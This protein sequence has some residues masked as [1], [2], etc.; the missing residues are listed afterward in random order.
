MFPKGFA[1]L[2]RAKPFS[3][4]TL[5]VMNFIFLIKVFLI[6]VIVLVLLIIL[7]ERLILVGKIYAGNKTTYFKEGLFSFTE[8]PEPEKGFADILKWNTER[9]ST[10]WNEPYTTDTISLT[11]FDADSFKV[12]STFINHATVLIE[13]KEYRLLTDPIFSKRV[14]PFSFIG[15]ARHHDPYLPLK[16]IPSLDFVLISHAHYDHLSIE[17]IK[18]IEEYF[19]PIYVTPLNNGQFIEQAGVPRNRIVEVNLFETFEQAGLR[20]T[21]EKA[22][23]WSA[24]GFSDRKRYLWGSFMIETADKNIYFSGDTGYDTHFKEIKEKYQRVDMAFIPIGAYEPRW[25]MKDYHMNP[26]EA[27]TAGKD[28][29]EPA[30]MGIHFGTFKITDEGRH[31]PERHTKEALKKTPYGNTF[32]VPTIQNGLQIELQ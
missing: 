13:T 28:L 30:V 2:M 22:K 11:P 12:R 20:I 15:P 32:L 5:L 19:S 27:V 21:L 24:R 31:D 23:H 16:E 9:N 25:F 18:M 7:F 29:G 1:S 3:F 4:G 8:Y 26:E 6:T 10:P 14:S 17:S